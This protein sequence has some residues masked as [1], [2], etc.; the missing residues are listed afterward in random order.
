[1]GADHPAHKRP[2]HIGRD[3]IAH[4][5]VGRP[6]V[7]PIEAVNFIVPVKVR[8]KLLEFGQSIIISEAVLRKGLTGDHHRFGGPMFVAVAA[9]RGIASRIG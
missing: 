1:M 8:E 2:S 3:D 7:P 9:K 5:L 4:G 6:Q